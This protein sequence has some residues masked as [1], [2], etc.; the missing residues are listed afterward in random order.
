MRRG[1]EID[2]K[3]GILL[4][5]SVRTFWDSGQKDNGPCF[6]GGIKANYVSSFDAAEPKDNMMANTF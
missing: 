2:E 4:T 3:Y 5:F 1:W 6:W